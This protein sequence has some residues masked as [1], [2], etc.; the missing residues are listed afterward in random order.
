MVGSCNFISHHTCFTLSLL[1][2]EAPADSAAPAGWRGGAS[3]AAAGVVGLMWFPWGLYFDGGDTCTK[4]NDFLKIISNLSLCSALVR[5]LY[6]PLP[7]LSA[8]RW[9]R[10]Q[11]M[12]PRVH[13]IADEPRSMGTII[14]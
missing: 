10:P 7:L 8:N 4:A 11:F 3:A 14:G 2:M 13:L 6:P 1:I 9:Q 5:S 12:S